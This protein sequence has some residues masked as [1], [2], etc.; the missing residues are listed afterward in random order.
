MT[1]KK[2]NAQEE[3]ITSEELEFLNDILKD[4]DFLWD[5]NIKSDDPLVNWVISE[6]IKRSESLDLLYEE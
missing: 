4:E 6:R 1:V 3:D 5:W 2:Y